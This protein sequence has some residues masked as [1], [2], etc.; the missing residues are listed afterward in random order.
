MSSVP[1]TPTQPTALGLGLDVGGTATRWA[2]ADRAGRLCAE[3]ELEA[4][5]GNPLD[6]TD[7]QRVRTQLAALAAQLAPHLQGA[8]LGGVLA[9]LTGFDPA[10]ASTPTLR[11]IWSGALGLP[12]ESIRLSNDIVMGYLAHFQ[13]GQGYMVYAGTGS[14]AAYIDEQGGLHRVGGRGHVLDDGGSAVW[15]VCQAFKEI[16]RTE[17]DTPG[18]WRNSAL[19]RALMQAV[20]GSE[21]SATRNFIY[22][23]QRGT[24]GRLALL[25]ASC[26]PTD[27]LAHS[28]L[29]RAGDELARL[30]QVLVTRFGVRPVILSGRAAGLHSSILSAMHARLGPGVSLSYGP[31]RSHQRAAELANDGSPWLTELLAATTE[32]PR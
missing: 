10:G 18:A 24:I 12:K 9:G 5:P 32:R 23:Q 7:W 11:Q 29:E 6:E 27:P 4:M 21:W 14:V 30:A 20:G 31:M 8:E 1:A 13:P 28:L 26:A 17:E 15:M 16:W 3:G 25:V 2:L 19:A 22:R